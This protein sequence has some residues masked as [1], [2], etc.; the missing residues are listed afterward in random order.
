MGNAKIKANMWPLHSGAQ[1][2]N[3]CSGFRFCH[4]KAVDLLE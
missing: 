3:R 2:G 1:V 4:L